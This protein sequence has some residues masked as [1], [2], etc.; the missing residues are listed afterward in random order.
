[1]FD[2]GPMPTG[3]RFCINGV[4]LKFVII[5]ILIQLGALKSNYVLKFK[6]YLVLKPFQKLYLND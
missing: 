5:P 2:D 6:T 4:A 1:M 3:E